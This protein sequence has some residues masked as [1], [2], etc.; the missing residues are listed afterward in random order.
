MDRH[1]RVVLRDRHVDPERHPAQGVDDRQ[2]EKIPCHPLHAF[3]PICHLPAHEWVCEARRAVCRAGRR[4]TISSPGAVTLARRDAPAGVSQMDAPFYFTLENTG[5][6][7][8]PTISLLWP[9]P[10]A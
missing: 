2:R 7:Q 6:C 3:P 10:E 9:L 5:V 8:A 4:K 1:L